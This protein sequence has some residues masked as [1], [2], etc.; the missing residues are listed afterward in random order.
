MNL[1]YYGSLLDQAAK[2]GAAFAFADDKNVSPQ[3]MAA[4]AAPA[5]ATSPRCAP[6]AVRSS[7]PPVSLNQGIPAADGTWLEQEPGNGMGHYRL[8]AGYDNAA[9][10]W[11]AYDSY[12]SHGLVKGQ[13][14][15]GIRLPYAEVARD[16]PVFNRT[17]LLIY[18]EACGSGGGKDREGRP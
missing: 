3:E 15:A 6:A 4:Y 1:S 13:P 10:R 14:Y 12:D 2:I 18:D 5:K 9:Q 7:R 17:Y 16:W 8:L 11:T